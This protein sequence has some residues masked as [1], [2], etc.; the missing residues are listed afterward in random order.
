MKNYLLNKLLPI[1][2]EYTDYLANIYKY[3][4]NLTVMTAHR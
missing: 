3:I 2:N 4:Q 1:N